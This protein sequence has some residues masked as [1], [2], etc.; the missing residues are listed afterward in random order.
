MLNEI[1]VVYC[2]NHTKQKLHCADKVQSSLM[3]R[4][5]AQDC[6]VYEKTKHQEERM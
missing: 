1:N 2:G 6:R 4:L 5:I 3:S